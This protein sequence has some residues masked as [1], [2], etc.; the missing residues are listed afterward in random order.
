LEEDRGILF[1]LKTSLTLFSVR[2][3]K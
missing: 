1:T 2:L 3:L